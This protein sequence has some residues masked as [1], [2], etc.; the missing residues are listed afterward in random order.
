[1][2][3]LWRNGR[4]GAYSGLSSARPPPIHV[5]ITEHTRACLRASTATGSPRLLN[6]V[7]DP[8]HGS[9]TIFRLP[10]D[11]RSPPGDCSRSRPG[12]RR[13]IGPRAS[14][15]CAVRSV[16]APLR[17]RRLSSS[18]VSVMLW[19]SVSIVKLF[20][21]LVLSQRLP[22]YHIHHSGQGTKQANSARIAWDREDPSRSRGG[23]DERASRAAIGRKKAARYRRVRPQGRRN[24]PPVGLASESNAAL[25]AKYRTSR[26]LIEARRA[27]VSQ[28][29][30][31]CNTLRSPQYRL[32]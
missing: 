16:R 15:A 5:L 7:P 24:K 20:M 22:R 11:R 29:T 2:G 12:G 26:M 14:P 21:V 9:R 30:H 8:R 6:F 27:G 28:R 4:V 18:G 31:G 25:V 3:V 13:A 17:I 19:V 1:M 10:R 23:N 32:C